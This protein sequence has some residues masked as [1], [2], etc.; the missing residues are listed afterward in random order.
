MLA[1]GAVR[2]GVG[3]TVDGIG[4]TDGIDGAAELFSESSSRVVLGTE[5]PAEVLA[6]ADAAGV[7]ARVIG[8]AG[9]DGVVVVGLLDLAVSDA[10]DAWRRALPG[11]LGEAVPA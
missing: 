8:T 2:S 5:R 3:C 4:S 10:D 9:G 1:E 6:D 11:A 7:P